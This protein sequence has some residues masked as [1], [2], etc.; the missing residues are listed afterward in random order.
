ME[1][2]SLPANLTF[3]KGKNE[4]ESIISIWPCFPGYGTT[5]GNALRRVLLS[6][7][8]GAAITSFKVKGAQHEF[9]A[10]QNVKEDLVE[11]SLNL[12]KVRLKLHGDEPQKIQISVKGAKIVKAGDIKTPSQVEVVN[13][14]LVLANLT[15]KDAELEMEMTV[16]K[17]RGYITTESREKEE[18]EVGQ[19]NIDA[20]YS[21]IVNVGFKLE[22]VRVG[23]MTNFDKLLITLETDGTITTQEALKQSTQILMEHFNYIDSSIL[24]GKEET[25]KTKKSKKEKDE[26]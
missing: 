12:K 23:Q 25:K 15:E 3:E 18:T 19:I 21:P 10:L 9:S 26:K 4:N 17:G 7:L 1:K 13:K 11:I 8:E 6:S 16:K 22:N 5:I 24:A 20:I 14:D 2:I